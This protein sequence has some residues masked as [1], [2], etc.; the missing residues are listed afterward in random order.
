MDADPAKLAFFPVAANILRRGDVDEAPA[1]FRLVLPRE[2]VADLLVDVRG[3][4]MRQLW[5]RE[6]IE[7][8]AALTSRLTVE[9]GDVSEPEMGLSDSLGGRLQTVTW[10]PDEVGGGTFIVDAQHT[11]VAL[12]NVAGRAL[13]FFGINI[14]VGE[15]D[16]GF[17]AVALTSMDGKELLDSERMLLVVMSGCENQEMGWD[18]ERT[19]VKREWGHG[20]TICEGVPAT[21]TF[22]N[23]PDLVAWA[24]DG[25][26][27]RG[28][29]IEPQADGSFDFGPRYRTI[30]YEIAAQ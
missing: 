19:T 21:V 13:R 23:R 29:R 16:T 18:A 10:T 3:G 26:G 1:S 30:W 20:P 6:G 14:D 28:E 24:L 17:S 2:Q 9:F 27:R 7:A 12:G 22:P 11:V 15:T 25:E 5:S 8:T 4:D